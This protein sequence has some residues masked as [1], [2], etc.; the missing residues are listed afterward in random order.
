MSKFLTPESVATRLDVAYFSPE[1]LSKLKRIFEAVCLEEGV[2]SEE[3]RDYLAINLLEAAT[4]TNDERT[5]IEVMK[6]DIAGHR[7]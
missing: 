4:F 7:K 6:Y 1:R 2:A 5:L 3:L